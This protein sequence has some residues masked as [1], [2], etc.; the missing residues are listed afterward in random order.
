M[1]LNNISTAEEENIKAGK[2]LRSSTA[3]AVDVPKDAKKDAMIEKQEEER[4]A[5]AR[6]K[7]KAARSEANKSAELPIE[8]WK[9]NKDLLPK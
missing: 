4:L 3:Q 1:G 8:F 5:N 9:K 2:K 6:A 7:L